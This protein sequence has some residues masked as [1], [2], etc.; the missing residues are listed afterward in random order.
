MQAFDSLHASYGRF[1]PGWRG[2]GSS[3]AHVGWTEGI[4]RPRA[5]FAEKRDGLGFEDHQRN[6]LA[7][8]LPGNGEDAF[9]ANGVADR[10]VS[11]CL[12]AVSLNALGGLA[13]L[14]KQ[15]GFGRPTNSRDKA[16]YEGLSKQTRFCSLCRRE[17]HKK[18]QPRK[19]R[20]CKNC[21]MEGH[22]GNIMHET[23]WWSGESNVIT[24]L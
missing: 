13:A 17:G 18:K 15:R 9:F 3:R 16:P 7:G 2:C 5:S 14:E 10:E 6:L 19:P 12:P 20:K 23:A 4:A 21:G 1:S 11:A 8:G 24:R 22:R